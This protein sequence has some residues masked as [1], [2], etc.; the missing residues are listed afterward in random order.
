VENLR[1]EQ[2]RLLFRL[3]GEVGEIADPEARDRHLSL[4]LCA[5]V[6][7]QVVAHA[8][9][10]E[11]RS[12]GRAWVSAVRDHGWA[13]ESDRQGVVAAW[14]REG[15]AVDPAV[16]AFASAFA[17]GRQVVRRDQVVD[18]RRWYESEFVA[19]CLSLARIDHGV[20]SAVGRPG[21]DTIHGLACFRPAGDR[22][23]TDEDSNLIH[24]VHDQWS[25]FCRDRRRVDALPKLRLRPRERQALDLLLEGMSEKEAADRMAVSPHTLHQ[26]VKALYRAYGVSSRAQLLAVCL[27]D[28][29]P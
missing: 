13:T 22:P 19:D 7:A 21:P 5:I 12:G 6:R 29:L 18:D 24:L 26:Y 2:V 20:Y 11:F 1:S 25:W 10:R 16:S 9:V 15:A 28:S 17:E 3:A 23:F 8:E 4:G 14:V 27:R